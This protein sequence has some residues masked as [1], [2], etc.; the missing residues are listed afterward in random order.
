[1]ATARAPRAAPSRSSGPSGLAEAGIAPWLAAGVRPGGGPAGSVVASGSGG[2]RVTT[3]PRWDA[4]QHH[5]LERREAGVEPLR[6]GPPGRQRLLGLALDGDQ[7]R[8]VRARP[9]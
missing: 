8:S 2:T 1:M 3:P 5:R 4:H 7:D 6:Q 9:G